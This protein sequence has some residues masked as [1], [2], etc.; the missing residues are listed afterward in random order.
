MVIFLVLMMAVVSFAFEVMEFGWISDVHVSSPTDGP[1]P[2]IGTCAT[3]PATSRRGDNAVISLSPCVGKIANAMDYFINEAVDFVVFSGDNV[4]IVSSNT[5]EEI[6]TRVIDCTSDYDIPIYFVFGNHDVASTGTGS[7]T[8]SEVLNHIGQQNRTEIDTAYYSFDVK[9]YHFIILDVNYTN[10]TSYFTISSAVPN[11]PNAEA[12]WLIADLLLNKDKPTFVFGHQFWMDYGAGDEELPANWI[13]NGQGLQAILETHGNVQ[14]YFNGHQHDSDYLLVNGIHYFQIM[15]TQDGCKF[16]PLVDLNDNS[17]LTVS[18]E[19]GNLVSID[20]T[21]A[22][23]AAHN[24]VSGDTFTLHDPDDSSGLEGDY[25]A[26][27]STTTAVLWFD[28]GGDFSGTPFNTENYIEDTSATADA[29]EAYT[30]LSISATGVVTVADQKAADNNG[31]WVAGFD[32]DMGKVKITIDNTKVSGS[33]H[34]YNF[35]VLITEDNM[36]DSFWENV[37]SDGSDI[38][39]SSISSDVEYPREIIAETFDSSGKIMEMWIKVPVLL[40]DEDT[41]FLI[42]YG[43]SGIYAN[44]TEVWDSDYEMVQ[45]L[46]EQPD[47][48]ADE[49]VDSTDN[50]ND[51]ISNVSGDATLATG[52]IGQ[53]LDF[54]AHDMHIDC[55]DSPSWDLTD[56][57]FSAW[58][59][60]ED[61]AGH[62]GTSEMRVIDK[63][64]NTA[65]AVNGDGGGELLWWAGNWNAET[66]AAL[67]DDTWFYYQ[68]TRTGGSTAQFYI[69]GA[70]EGSPFTDS[71]SIIVNSA[72][73]SIG[74]GIGQSDD[75]H[76]SIDEMRV[77]NIAKS[78]DWIATEFS[79]QAQATRA[80]F[81]SA[82]VYIPINKT[83][84]PATGQINGVLQ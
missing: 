22:F 20:W 76:G 1:L 41:E 42:H 30:K 4:S 52:Q 13:Q 83:G 16:I 66:F 51:G 49:V 54:T 28:A 2:N 17:S 55:G 47:G 74:G 72:I 46:N 18:D 12:N 23:D 39:V 80:A 70:T 82:E 6:W 77:L 78:A 36:P 45:H 57:T 15:A 64:A 7:A 32:I 53:A 29:Y 8:L 19:A 14:A 34:L 27:A 62:T 33:D 58:I 68:V 81:Y 71:T 73:L 56:F 24:L 9:G 50:N 11:L 44:S 63:S 61:L 59:R 79:N 48:T 67:T 43:G 25:T 26:H 38:F 37:Q 75:W 21:G 84:V 60:P 10:G 5:W 65:F 31:A 3:N 35:P 40:Y 69:D